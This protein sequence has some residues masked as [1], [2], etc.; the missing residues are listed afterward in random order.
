[1]CD[2]VQLMLRFSYYYSRVLGVLNFKIDNESGEARI[3]SLSTIYAAIANL[4]I[5]CLLPLLTRSELIH[6]MWKHAGFLHEYIFLV[7]LSMRILCVLATLFSRWWQRRRIVRLVNAFRR[8]TI[9]RPQVIRLWRHG[10]IMKFISIVVTETVQ[11]MGFIYTLRR[12]LT[13]NLILS[14]M[15]VY[16]V[17]ALVNVIIAHFYFAMLNIHI[18]NVLLKQEL[19]SVLAEIRS[20]EFEHRRGTFMSKCC[21]LADRLEE[22]ARRQ[23]ELQTLGIR[24]VR[25]FGLQGLCISGSSYMSSIGC[26]YFTVSAL[27]RSAGQKWSPI[28]FITLIFEVGTYFVDILITV[29]NVYHIIDDHSDL[30]H[31]MEQYTSFA[32]G[33]DNRLDAVSQSKKQHHLQQILL[34]IQRRIQLQL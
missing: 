2:L 7:V 20:L 26:I 25:V 21:S 14:I 15:A 13:L 18:H 16:L 29:Y 9:R 12:F 8:L 5:C 34:R 3:T 10:V 1:M 33:L 22:I 11:M 19:R 4:T 30:V 6:I 24:M 23:S 31:M 27:K 32:P 17:A 28:L